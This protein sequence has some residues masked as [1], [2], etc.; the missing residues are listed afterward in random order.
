MNFSDLS[1][2]AQKIIELLGGESAAL[3]DEVDVASVIEA[4]PELLPGLNQWTK[5]RGDCMHSIERQDSARPIGHGVSETLK[6]LG[7]KKK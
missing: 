7:E 1:P 3:S 4:H 5:W 6:K 2:E